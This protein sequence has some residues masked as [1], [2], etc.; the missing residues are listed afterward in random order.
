MNTPPELLRCSGCKEFKPHFEF[1]KMAKNKSRG[2][3]HYYCREC[4]TAER[5]LRRAQEHQSQSGSEGINGKACSLAR[6][7]SE[8]GIS[9]KAAQMA[10]RRA[11][12]KARQVLEDLG[13]TL[14]DLIGDPEQDERQLWPETN[15]VESRLMRVKSK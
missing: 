11:L 13:Y 2:G 1:A 6:I 5:T 3:R 9:I 10:E 15:Y 8:L 4:D 12:K 7:A 14:A